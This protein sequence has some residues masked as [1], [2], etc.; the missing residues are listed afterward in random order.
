MIYLLVAVGAFVSIITT[1]IFNSIRKAQEHYRL[2]RAI[3]VLVSFVVFISVCVFLLG[4][5]GY[6]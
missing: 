2:K 3:V 6:Q 1:A 4:Q 5:K